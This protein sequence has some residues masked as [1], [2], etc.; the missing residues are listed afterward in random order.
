MTR[1]AFVPRDYQAEVVK[2]TVS[3]VQ[4]G[5][6]AG[7]VC[8][9][10]GTGKASLPALVFK[11]LFQA[12]P[13]ARAMMVTHRKTLIEQN[14]NTL[15]WIWPDAP[16]GIYSAGLKRR[17]TMDA[18][19]Y[20]GI[21]SIHRRPEAFGKIDYCIVDEAHLIPEDSETMYGSFL[22]SL[23]SVNPDMVLIGMTATP[24][25]LKTGMLLDGPMFDD[26]IV[27]RT[28]G[29]DFTW[30]IDQGYLV[31]V[32]PKD[33]DERMSPEGVKKSGG[34]YTIASLA[35][36][37][38]RR[39][40]SERLVKEV[41]A[42]RGKR[43][44]GITFAINIE[45]AEELAALY[46]REGIPATVAH[47][48]LDTATA[49]ANL[50][51][52]I[53]GEY[54]ML[55]DVEKYT[56]GFDCPWI[57]LIVMARLTES[58]SLSIQMLGRGTRPVYA[59]GH[60]LSTKEGRLAAI[61]A[62]RKPNGCLVL[63]F[64]ANSLRL[65][66]INA[67]IT[68]AN[69][70]QVDGLGTELA[71]MKQCPKCRSHIHA[72]KRF[73]GEV[74]DDGVACDHEFPMGEEVAMSGEV[75]P[76]LLIRREGSREERL[77]DVTESVVSAGRSL[78]GIPFVSVMVRVRGLPL[79]YTERLYLTDRAWFHNNGTWNVLL[80]NG[81]QFPYRRGASDD[82]NLKACEDV[83]RNKFN[84]TKLIVWTNHMAEGKVVPKIVGVA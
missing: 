73:C 74:S 25:R 45:H 67:P 14:Y 81:P 68:M 52:F 69:K 19:T 11:E 84:P 29:D 63:D 79:P 71:P 2:S 54:E 47:S 56:T 65:G 61:T 30:F 44:C 17:D 6:K 13:F 39:E 31:D 77:F 34:E 55:V 80:P 1:P 49:E 3:Y 48:K 20:A 57:D 16:C 50:A 26:M 51:A 8:L 15:K 58:P 43:R 40:V 12:N 83:L 42:R 27:D 32:K 76:G 78:R 66:P 7:L 82:E 75:I 18:I 35:A 41:A 28:L 70:R 24:F 37:F 72:A 64:A 23:R 10:T 53:A 60:D 22:E 38:N 36:K 9:P 4:G 5:G 59:P 33:V 46:D 62:S 21:Q